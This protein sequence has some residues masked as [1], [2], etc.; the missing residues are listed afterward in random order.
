MKSQWQIRAEHAERTLTKIDDLF[1]YRSNRIDRHLLKDTVYSLLYEYTREL[2]K[3][4]GDAAEVPTKG[5]EGQDEV[6][7]ES[8]TQTPE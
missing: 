6:S 7:P 8:K 2:R 3:E 1:E 4:L 5:G